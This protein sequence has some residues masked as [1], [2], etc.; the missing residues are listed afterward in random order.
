MSTFRP[1][2]EL[3]F[4]ERDPLRSSEEKQELDEQVIVVDGNTSGYEPSLVSAL[5]RTFWR[6]L[7]LGALLK[8]VQTLLVFV[9]PQILK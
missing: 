7:L 4:T 6:S 8:L 3:D 5:F 2:L 9:S 1:S